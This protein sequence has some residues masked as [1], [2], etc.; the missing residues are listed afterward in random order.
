MS[1]MTN[2]DKNWGPFTLGRWTKTFCIEFSTGDKEDGPMQNQLIFI[3]FGWGLRIKLPNLIQCARKRV[4]AGWDA[5]TVKRLGRDYYFN[6]WDRRFGVTLSDMGNGYDFLQLKYG[7]ETHDS[8]TTKSWCKHLP[9][10]QWDHVRH[11]IY[12]PDG[13]HFYTE[14][15]WKDRRK[16]KAK[17]TFE[18]KEECPAC[19]FGFE[20]YD[21]EM[22]VATCHI[23]EREWRKGSGWFRW[24]KYFNKPKIHRVLDLQFSA[25]VG[26][27][28]GSWKGG[29][30]GHSCEMV[31]GDTPETAFRRY[32]E[33]E[34]E[35]KGRKF[36]LRFIGPCG[37]PPKVK[38][39][40]IPAA[41]C[42]KP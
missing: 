19:H 15:Y 38:K 39:N 29:T 11:S 30:I 37:A 27:E 1:R 6:T 2:N 25:E 33:K 24:L 12:T 36:R 28:K 18:V 21:G 41:S 35:R 17:H 16:A 8:S 3:G 34:H 31:A 4:Q 22:I 23:E 13:T 40:E 14:P 32:C 5:A 9:W 26:T 7:R 42:I 20:D 10:M